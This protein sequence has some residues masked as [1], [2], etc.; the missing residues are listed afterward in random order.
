MAEAQT[1]AQ[2][3]REAALA[4]AEVSITPR[5]DAEHL[6]AFALGVSRSE[7]LL[8]HMGDSVPSAFE[9][10][11]ARR[12]AHEPIG[13][14]L[15]EEV[16]FGLT[17]R[18]SPAVLIPRPDSEVL[19]RCALAARPDARR[20]LDCGTGSGALLLAVLSRLDYARGI[21]I[22]RS[23]A[24]LD[25]AR[26]NARALGMAERAM[27]TLADWTLA[28]WLKGFG[29]PFDLVL[30]NPPYVENDAILEPS[31]RDHEP[32]GA[33]FAGPEGLDDYRVLVPQLGALL[34]P[35]GV[36]CVEIGAG[37]AE[38]VSALAEAAG[39]AATVHHDLAG[40]S[41]VVEMSLRR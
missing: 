29:G 32:V 1:V 38:A 7:L 3:L 31:V 20:V 26:D 21:G 40:R 17:F 10:I 30:A 23:Q 27:M 22:D 15:G 24:A 11:I 41:R 35:G 36:A 12:I 33:L 5:A 19:V 13:Y 8:R 28:G 16:F 14:I 4:L 39:L 18:V 6:M 34:A 25:I 2:A 9:G 37:Q